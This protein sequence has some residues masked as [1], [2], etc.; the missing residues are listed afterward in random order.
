MESS[1]IKFAIVHYPY[2]LIKTSGRIQLMP[3]KWYII[4]YMLFYSFSNAN[5][6]KQSHTFVHAELLTY[7]C[8]LRNLFSTHTSLSISG[9][10]D[11]LQLLIGIAFYKFDIL[12]CEKK[13]F[14][15][16]IKYFLAQTW[17]EQSA[18]CWIDVQDSCMPS[19]TSKYTFGTKEF[20]YPKNI[21]ISCA[22]IQFSSSVSSN[23]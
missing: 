2:L 9:S 4:S 20:K 19:H 3:L 21:D 6:T 18:C 16:E 17:K 10:H 13:V 11:Y 5:W 23:H 22:I 7:Y 15:K 12:L 8:L 1:N 14:G